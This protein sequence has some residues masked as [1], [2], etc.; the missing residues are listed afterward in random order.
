MS[1]NF[2]ST[3]IHDAS[4]HDPFEGA[5]TFTLKHRLTRLAFGIVWLLFARWT[6]P[7]MQRWRVMVLNLFGA[8]IH[9]T[10][11][12]RSSAKIWFPKNLKMAAYS[13]LGPGVD[14]YCMALISIG[15]RAV[16]SQRAYLCAGSHRIDDKY[17]QLIAKPIV[18][19]DK[20]WI[21]AETFVGPGVVVEEGAVLGAR[22][23]ATRNLCSWTVYVGNPA[24]SIGKREIIRE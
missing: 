24:I 8:N 14:C 3:D 6:P 20:A 13:S 23:V 21:A 15:E 22:G 19:E 2:D 1:D 18:I 4:Q 10:A 17:F 16:V 5:S 11:N 9:P 12:V 7:Q